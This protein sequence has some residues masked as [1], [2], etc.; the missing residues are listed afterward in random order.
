MTHDILEQKS[1]QEP[2]LNWRARDRGGATARG[3]TM[4]KIQCVSECGLELSPKR[5]PQRSEAP[6]TC[7]QPKGDFSLREC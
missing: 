4:Y 5:K 3:N 1:Q 2:K 7:K 6:R